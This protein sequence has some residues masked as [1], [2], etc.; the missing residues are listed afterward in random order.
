LVFTHL[1][2]QTEE[3]YFLKNGWACDFLVLPTANQ[4]LI[5]QVTEHLTLDNL[6]RKIMGLEM[7]RKRIPNS[8]G[9][10]LAGQLDQTVNLPDWCDVM[11]IST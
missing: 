8:K 7:A 10:L 4:S 1:R 9:L 11:P 5:I 2:A 6:S 3:I